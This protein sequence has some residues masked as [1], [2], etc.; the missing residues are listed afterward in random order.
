MKKATPN[1]KMKL[2]SAAEAKLGASSGISV[3]FFSPKCVVL[4][5]A[6]HQERASARS[7]LQPGGEPLA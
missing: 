2:V 1:A 7:G 4:A 5:L 6:A 3:R